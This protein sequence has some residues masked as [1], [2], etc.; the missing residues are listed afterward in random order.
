[1]IITNSLSDMADAIGA[2]LDDSGK[3]P[4]MYTTTVTREMVDL[5]KAWGGDIRICLHENTESPVQDMIVIA[6]PEETP[7]TPHLHRGQSETWHV[8]AGG[9]VVYLFTDDGTL[10]EE[11]LLTPG[12][13]PFLIPADTYHTAKPLTTVV[14]RETKAGPAVKSYFAEWIS[15]WSGSW[16]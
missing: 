5:L 8:L 12:G 15:D 2:R 7:K 16:C 13:Y 4:A 11:R 6:H 9:L 10:L 1:M 14:F 3:S